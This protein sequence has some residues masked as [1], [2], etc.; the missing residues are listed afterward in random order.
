MSA[1][2]NRPTQNHHLVV[3]D[4]ETF[5]EEDDEVVELTSA[6]ARTI[7]TTIPGGYQLESQ[8]YDS[9]PAPVVSH[10][11]RPSSR[12]SNTTTA[13]T[14][15]STSSSDNNSNSIG[16]N[17]RSFLASR[18]PTVL[19]AR[20]G[21]QTSEPT[22]TAEGHGLL[23]SSVEEE[24]EDDEEAPA[25]STRSTY[26]PSNHIPLPARP[27]S[28]PAPRVPTGRVFGG[29]QGNDGV[30]RP[31]P[32]SRPWFPPSKPVVVSPLF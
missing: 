12:S 28:F 15:S 8:T 13:T 26:P 22:T 4:F 16:S 19:A 10:S 25:R 3:N 2:F 32:S 11:T 7:P 27:H 1:F 29:G 23:F 20:F 24:E 30:V 31:L 17:A 9:L 21:L 18:L 6:A 14:S 5:D